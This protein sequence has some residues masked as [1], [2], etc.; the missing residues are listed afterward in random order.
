MTAPQNPRVTQAPCSMG[1]G[2]D[3]Y[4]VCYA[5]AHGQPEQCPHYTPSATQ[6]LQAELLGA[7]EFL[8]NAARAAKGFASPL[9]LAEADKV[10]A[11]AK[12]GEV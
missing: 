3:E 10:L 5:E 6:A 7:L 2:C 11:K 4:G 12:G 1:V 8:A 9:A